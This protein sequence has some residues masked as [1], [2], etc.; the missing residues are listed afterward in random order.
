MSLAPSAGRRRSPAHPTRPTPAPCD[1]AGAAAGGAAAGRVELG[2]HG[3]VGAAEPAAGRWLAGLDR[4]PHPGRVGRDHPGEGAAQRVGQLGGVG[5]PL[6]ADRDWDHHWSVAGGGQGPLGGQRPRQVSPD[7]QH[8]HLSHLQH[9]RCDRP[10]QQPPR[11]DHHQVQALRRCGRHPAARETAS[12]CSS[13]AA[14]GRARPTSTRSL[15]VTCAIPPPRPRGRAGGAAIPAAVPGH[16]A[17]RRPADARRRPRRRG[18]DPPATPNGRPPPTRWPGRPPGWSP[19]VRPCR[20]S[21]PPA[22]PPSRPRPWAAA[23]GRR[24]PGRP[25]PAAAPPPAA[26]PH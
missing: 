17:H 5:R 6:H 26:P 20:R 13:P 1:A 9:R 4:P 19:L 8:P 23:P 14:S 2:G 25:G 21:P 10:R 16:G 18:P 24:C 11:I 3:A 7:R 15:G 22:A 12:R